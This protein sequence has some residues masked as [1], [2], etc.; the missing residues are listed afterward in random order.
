MGFD[1]GYRVTY[2]AEDAL[3]TANVQHK[4]R[5][6]CRQAE[7]R[8]A[9]LVVTKG[10]VVVCVDATCADERRS[11]SDAQYDFARQQLKQHLACSQLSIVSE[12]SATVAHLFVRCRRDDGTPAYTVKLHSGCLANTSWLNWRESS[13]VDHTTMHDKLQLTGT[14]ALVGRVVNEDP[15]DAVAVEVEV[16]DLLPPAGSHVQPDLLPEVFR[17]SKQLVRLRAIQI[18]ARRDTTGEWPLNTTN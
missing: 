11:P 3:V 7:Q 10:A 16:A 4:R 2:R 13:R 15:V 6:A 17:Q 18:P 8:K 1:G 12:S 5:L 9:E 14:L